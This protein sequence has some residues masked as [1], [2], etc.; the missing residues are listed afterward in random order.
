MSVKIGVSPISWTNDDMPELGRDT[1]VEHCLKEGKQA[2]YS[3]FELGGKW[4]RETSILEPL[5]NKY[6]MD[7]VSSWFCGGLLK[8]SIEV[9][10]K[11]I[12]PH[13]QL[14]KDLGTDVIVYCEMDACVHGDISSP[15]SMRPTL[16]EDQWQDW[17]DKLN[18]LA[19]YTLSHGMQLA[20]HHHMGTIVQIEEEVDK[21]MAMTNKDLGLVLDTGHLIYAGSDPLK[22]YEKYSDRV[23]HIH[24]KDVRGA[25]LDD[26]LKADSSFL[27][28]VLNGVFTVPGDGDF[29]FPGLFKMVSDNEY[30]GWI[31]VEAEQDPAKAHPLTYVTMGYKNIESYCE[32]F[33]IQIEKKA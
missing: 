24:C 1:T 17:T 19:K 5:F 31:V 20:Y 28:S 2:G 12:T 26:S 10:I 23:L 8:D 22:V 3:G 33:G 15:L 32:K 25:A 4:P 9:E 13:M 27:N 21:L 7:V 16:S 29:D 14:L 30:S 18:Q 11:R 6:N